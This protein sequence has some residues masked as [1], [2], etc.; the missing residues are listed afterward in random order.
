MRKRAMIVPGC[1]EARDDRDLEPREPLDETVMLGA[2]VQHRQA[3]PP[4]PPGHL[5]QNFV[6][7]LGDIDRYQHGAIRHILGQGHGR[8]PLRWRLA[9]SRVKRPRARPRPTAALRGGA[10]AVH[11]L[12]NRPLPNVLWAGIYRSR[13]C[14]TWIA[15]VGAKTAYHRTRIALG[16][17]ILRKSFK[18]RFRD[19][20]LNSEIFF[21]LREAQILIEQWRRHYNTVRPHSALGYRPPAPRG[22]SVP[23]RP[24]C[25]VMH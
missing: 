19:E 7:V 23:D 13:K 11:G 9:T 22:N 15:A 4:G 24:Q 14:G 2:R 18:A 21:S 3:P 6:A 5:D 12:L 16:E 25:S 10:A 8:S 17:R 20:L 1:L